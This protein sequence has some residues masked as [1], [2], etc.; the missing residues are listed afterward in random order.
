MRLQHQLCEYAQDFH[1]TPSDPP[2]DLQPYFLV[3]VRG[4]MTD[5]CDR[6]LLSNG[7]I[8]STSGSAFRCRDGGVVT[9]N[10]TGQRRSSSVVE[11]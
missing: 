5:T 1:P 11:P 7:F 3:L 4:E 8:S 6:E 10:G 9:W 2:D